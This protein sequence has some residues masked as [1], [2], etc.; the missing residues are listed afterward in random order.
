[1]ESL[2]V[3]STWRNSHWKEGEGEMFKILHRSEQ[4]VG[5]R[6]IWQFKHIPAYLNAR[7][8]PVRN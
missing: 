5:V 2:A 3:A 4:T 7:N 1:M 6:M 8:Q